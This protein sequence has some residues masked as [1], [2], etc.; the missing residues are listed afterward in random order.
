MAITIPQSTHDTIK[1]EKI[2]ENI[3]D[4]IESVP[5]AVKNNKHRRGSIDAPETAKRYAI[6]H[7]QAFLSDK[8]ISSHWVFQ[9]FSLIIWPFNQFFHRITYPNIHEKCDPNRA[10]LSINM[11]TTHNADISLGIVGM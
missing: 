3:I 7:K 11:H 2:Q 8:E 4:S 6:A 1:N 9:L 10:Y 5:D